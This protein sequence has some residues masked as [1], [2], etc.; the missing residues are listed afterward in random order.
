MPDTT[1]NP[2]IN[3]LQPG[4]YSVIDASALID[5]ERPT[6]R[7]VPAIIGTCLGGKP[8]TPLYFRGPG[9]LKQ[10]LRGGIAYDVARFAFA[11]GAERVCVMRVG[12]AI[13]QST[14]NLAGATGNPITLTSIDYGSWTTGIK[15]AVAANN[16]VTITFTDTLG[17][18][19]TE[20][21]ACGAGATVQDIADFINGKKYGVPA[22]QF[23][24]AA[25]AAGTL[26]LSVLASTALA[27]GTDGLTPANGDW[28]TGLAALETE[29]VSIVVPAT[30]NATIHA[31][32]LAHANNMSV[33]QARKERTVLTGG[34]VAET[35]ATALARM[36]GSLLDKRFQ[37]V[38]P[39]MYEF[40]ANGNL[41]LYDPFYAAGKLAGLHCA[42]EDPAYSLAH[43]TFPAIDIERRL[44]TIQGGDVDSLL[45]AGVT[46]IAPK[47]GGGFWIVDSLS[48]YRTD[49]TFRDFHKIR[50]ADFV[51]QYSRTILEGRFVGAKSLAGTIQSIQAVANQICADL[52]AQEIIRAFQT[53]VIT[54]GANTRTYNVSLPVMLVDATKFIFVT[55]ALQPSSTVNRDAG[56]SAADAN[57]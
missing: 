47:P 4:A 11:G 33:P 52:Q 54:P 1:I 23:V 25:T 49:D 35:P 17:T 36:T 28:T 42:L 18:T 13:T 43:K 20:T 12:N 45:A 10:A 53:P 5:A 16:L 19:Y 8:N 34:I 3:P 7:P 27:G 39:G 57:A 46:P 37:L 29:D 41:A 30:D 56:F 50:S 44:S 21:F 22:S 55:V 48:G 26:P 9:P 6:L 2:A 51:A 38:Y 31:L 32:A 40:D 14:K 15:V 24:T